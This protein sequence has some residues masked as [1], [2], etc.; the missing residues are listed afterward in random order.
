M[1]DFTSSKLPVSVKVNTRPYK[2]RLRYYLVHYFGVTPDGKFDRKTEYLKTLVGYA[3]PKNE[4]QRR[5]NKKSLKFAEELASDY[6]AQVRARTYNR[7]DQKLKGLY[8]IDHMLQWATKTYDK[9]SSIGQF[10]SISK[11]LRSYLNG[12]DILLSQ[13]DKSFCNGF[14]EHLKTTEPTLKGKLSDSAS[15]SYM[16]K[17]KFYLEQLVN[18]DFFP[19]SPAR[20]IKVG[21]AKVIGKEF[22]SS[23]ELKILEGHPTKW[24]IVKKYY[25]FAS[26]SAIT[27]AECLNLTFGDFYQ[28]D[29]GVWYVRVVRVKTGKEARLELGSE[30][31]DIISPMG[32]PDEK[33]FPNL[34]DGANFN[35]YLLEWVKSAG[36]DK[37]ITPH[38]AKNNFAVK[39][40]RE[41]GGS[42]FD[43]FKLMKHLQ[44][45]DISSTQRYLSGL[46]GNEYLI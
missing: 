40:Y 27:M 5:T 10:E 23:K 39:Y 9:K 28:D 8:L 19:R 33:V 22:L 2:D 30:A 17:F 41:N 3:N 18:D 13:V 32:N 26:Y 21:K 16:K 25:L 20:H 45:T 15:K 7:T 14:W 11:H 1:A 43:L 6:M 38:T 34:K 12:K 24:E 31:M 29:K 37:H 36:I 44:H 4:E 46:M 42:N 35:K